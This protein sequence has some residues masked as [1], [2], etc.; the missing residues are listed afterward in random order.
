MMRAIRNNVFFKNMLRY[1]YLL[2]LAMGLYSLL[3]LA[4]VRGNTVISEVIDRMLSGERIWF[5][6][7][8]LEFLC[9]T[10]A[11]FVIAFGANMAASKFALLVLTRYRK[12]V[13]QKLYRLEYRYFDENYSS[14]V[15]NKVN[16]DLGEAGNFLQESLITI[17]TNL[18]ALIVYANYVR[19][20]N[21]KLFLVVVLCYPV[22]FGIASVL[23]KKITELSKTYRAKT[24]A[25]IEV[26]QDAI[27][28]A[29]LVK[30]F[31]LQEYFAGRMH[32]ATVA[33]VDN[34]ER[35]TKISN[36]AM[37]VRKLIQWLPNIIC[38]VYSVTLVREGFLS[39]GELLA[40]IIVL[41]K[42][43]S[44]FVGLP[45]SFVDA[46]GSIVCIGRMEEILASPEESF[47]TEKP[48][49][50]NDVVLDFEKVSFGYYPGSTVLKELSFCVRRGEN[51][52]FVGESGGGKSTIFHLLCGFYK[53]QA[54]NY[55]LYGV[56]IEKW[57]I[58]SAR[59]RF[60][61]VSQNVFLFPVSIEENI[62]YGNENATHEQVVE[63]CE[64]AEI[65]DFIMTLPEQYR[66]IVGERG[67]LLS[68]GQK[69]RIS[70][71]RA[72]LKDAPI[73]LLDEPTSAIDEETEELIQRAL[74]RL[75][76]GKT[77]ITIAHR[78]STIKPADRIMV[79]KDG[80]IVESGTHDLLMEQ[81]GA[82]AA[83]YGA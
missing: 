3:N 55:R 54:G 29:Q 48:S 62:L 72:I 52:A 43:V 38:A 77:C 36:T 17:L 8:L 21:A 60:A 61:L 23:R 66:T 20:L 37:I 22:V 1:G 79:L 11:G 47:G 13:A 83:M 32:K 64:K 31:G 73:L 71:A 70:I 42:L 44:A 10:S 53:P 25:I 74:T 51:I 5:R 82:Y 9:L 50:E 81:N 41:G 40:F 33:L 76:R 46:A 65:H 56:D 24:D 30:T 34:E 58:A 18:I 45:F 39:V 15:I 28:G 6:S 67:S 57:D 2:L 68:G 14:S 26:D 78:L 7:F 59:D 63:A 35:R 75:S 19:R 80:Q 4:I 12:Q 16:A 27:S 69:Q 49:L